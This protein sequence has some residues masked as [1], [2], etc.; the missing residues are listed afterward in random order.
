MSY[1]PYERTGFV[2]EDTVGHWRSTSRPRLQIS[3]PS[4]SPSRVELLRR[5]G[6][7]L[8]RTLKHMR[9]GK[10]ISSCQ[11]TKMYGLA[12]FSLG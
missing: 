12:S 3:S 7:E 5:S 6:F 2:E 1:A 9:H 10:T 8:V 4:S 11:R